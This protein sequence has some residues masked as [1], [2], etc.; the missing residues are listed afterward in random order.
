MQTRKDKNKRRQERRAEK[1]LGIYAG[2]PRHPNNYVDNKDGTTTIIT[3]GGHKVL[4]DSDAILLIAGRRV[5][6]NGKGYAGLSVDAHSIPLHRFILSAPAGVD[7]DH[8]NRDRKDCRRSNLRFCSQSHNNANTK[9]RLDNS[10]GYRGVHFNKC[11]GRYIAQISIAGRG[12]HIGSFS[13]PEAA[14]IAYNE[15]AICIHGSFATINILK[16]VK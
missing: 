16:A 2:R 8:I 12:K 10:T 1:R 4:V 9:L 13:T 3:Y 6:I 14:A 15:Q 7:V 11:S 5:S